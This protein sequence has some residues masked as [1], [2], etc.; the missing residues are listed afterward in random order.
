MMKRTVIDRPPPPPGTRVRAS[1]V[2]NSG[3]IRVR[4]LWGWETGIGDK[5]HDDCYA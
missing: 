5:V 3:T 1:V 4:V 2:R